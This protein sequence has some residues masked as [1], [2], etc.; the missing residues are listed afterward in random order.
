MNFASQRETKLI[1]PWNHL[2]VLVSLLHLDLEGRKMQYVRGKASIC[3]GNSC[4]VLI[5]RKSTVYHWT[6]LP[7]IIPTSALHEDLWFSLLASGLT[8]MSVFVARVPPPVPPRRSPSR[9]AEEEEWSCSGCTFLN[10][11][12]IASCEICQTP[13]QTTSR[14]GNATSTKQPVKISTCKHQ[15]SCFCHA[16]LGWHF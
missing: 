16:H 13:R 3:L 14:P 8:S 6:N 10:H 11:P 4:H 9:V 2:P 7:F 5:C 1:G 15:S 12:L